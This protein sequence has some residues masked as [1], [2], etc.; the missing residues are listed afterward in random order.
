M[1]IEAP[2]SKAVF[3]DPERGTIEQLR[4]HGVSGCATP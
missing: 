1:N 4:Q 3:D 2:I